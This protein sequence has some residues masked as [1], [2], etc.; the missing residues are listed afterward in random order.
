MPELPEVETVK[1]TLQAKLVG[2]SFKGIRI[3]IPKVVQTPAAEQV[4]KMIA[5]AKIL[6]IGRRG[7][8]LL[9]HL[10]KELALVIHLRMTGK[11][12]YCPAGEPLAK[13]THV[14]FYLDNGDELRFA[15]MRK[16]GRLWVVPRSAL[17]ELPV[18]KKLGME[19]LEDSFTSEFLQKELPRRN[20]RI[21]PL[22]LDQGL[23]AGLGNIYT[24]EALHR[25]G[26]H[27]ERPAK[28]ITS[29]EADRLH[30][31][32]RTVLQ[33]GIKHKGTTISNFVDGNGRAGNYQ[34][35]LKVYKRAGQPCCRC[36][37][38]I[39]RKKVGG[40]SSYYCPCCQRI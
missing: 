4:E 19:P 36:G 1:Q 26:L 11:L 32:I 9:I 31:A 28:T 7:K 5:G 38:R 2:L 10:D 20:T 16:F 30:R 6:K 8:H 3:F 33:E 34:E 15:D 23:I 40:R 39:E 35:L 22:L 17:G 29:R 14:I 21:K 24:D 12:L 13:Y 18:L 37:K 27:P 25:A